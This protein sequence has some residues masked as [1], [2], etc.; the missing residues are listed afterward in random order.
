MSKNFKII[1]L[2]TFF[3]IFFSLPV[4]MT[5]LVHYWPIKNDLLDHIGTSNLYPGNVSMRGTVGFGP[6]RFGNPTGAIHCN[7]GYYFVQAG[8]YFTWGPFSVTLWAKPV[9]FTYGD[10][11]LDFGN[12]DNGQDNIIFALSSGSTGMPNDL[13]LAGTSFGNTCQV[14]TALTTN[15]WYHLGLV[16]DGTNLIFL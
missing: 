11:V 13:I 2:I 16:Y 9:N 5:N 15:V 14:G 7:T 6:D 10:R 12:T 3:F 4:N 8:V 1:K